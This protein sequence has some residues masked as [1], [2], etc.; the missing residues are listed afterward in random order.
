VS[1]HPLE[2]LTLQQEARFTA[3]QIALIALIQAHPNPGDLAAS[4]RKRVDETFK[5]NADSDQSDE[6][7]AITQEQFDLVLLPLLNVIPPR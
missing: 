5:A 3:T 4:L 1:L 2:K 7:K 6:R